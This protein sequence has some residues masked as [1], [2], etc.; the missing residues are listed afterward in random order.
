MVYAILP[1]C[2]FRF[3]SQKRTHFLT[4]VREVVLCKRL[5]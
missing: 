2:F 1:E 5:I 3:L 4:V